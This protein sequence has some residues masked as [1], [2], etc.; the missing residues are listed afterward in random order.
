MRVRRWA[1]TFPK[2]DMHITEDGHAHSPKMDMHI[3]QRWTCIFP[4]DRH[5]HSPPKID[6]HIPPKWTCTSPKMDMHIPEDGHAHP[7]KWTCTF[8]KMDMHIPQNG[9]AHSPKWTCTSPKMDM[10]MPRRWICASQNGHAHVILG[11]RR[12]SV[13]QV[14][15]TTNAA[16]DPPSDYT[17]IKSS[18]ASI[19]KT[20]SASIKNPLLQAET[21]TM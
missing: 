9:H 12:S 6:M 13:E 18:S 7:Q 5:A 1:C 14:R 16:S 10:H 19:K 20:S 4:Q 15:R 17:Y 8:P 2:M 11:R 3:P 21:L